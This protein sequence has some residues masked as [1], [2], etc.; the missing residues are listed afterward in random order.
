[1]SRPALNAPRRPRDA[2][3]GL[4]AEDLARGAII[5]LISLVAGYWILAPR[6]D[7]ALGPFEGRRLAYLGIAVALQLFVLGGNWL[8]RRFERAHGMDGQLAPDARHVL[9]LLA[10]GVSVLL[11][12][13][14][15]FG[16]IVGAANDI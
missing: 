9:Q 16:G 8:V 2:G 12:A 7:A 11:F 10:D 13:L 6:D 4:R 15:V 5:A 3:G 14:A 1:M